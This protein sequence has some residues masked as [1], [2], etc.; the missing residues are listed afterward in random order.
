MENRSFLYPISVVCFVKTH[1][2]FSVE[3]KI[4]CFQCRNSISYEI[5]GR[6]CDYQNKLITNLR[7]NVQKVKWSNLRHFRKKFRIFAWIFPINHFNVIFSGVRL[8]GNEHREQF[9][10]ETVESPPRKNG[11][12]WR[13]AAGSDYSKKEQFSV[14]AAQV[15]DFIENFG[16]HCWCCDL[17][18][19]TTHVF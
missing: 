6:F 4:L 2:D 19:L 8:L 7:K 9:F 17:M 13:H 15:S 12:K 1:S 5:L 18:L 14:N 11:F 3:M 16:E 10:L